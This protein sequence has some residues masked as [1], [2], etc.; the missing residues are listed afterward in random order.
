MVAATM[1][2]P[3]GNY[4]QLNLLSF[5]GE[6]IPSVDE[7]RAVHVFYHDFNRTPGAVPSLGED[8]NLREGFRG[9]DEH[10]VRGGSAAGMTVYSTSKT[11]SSFGYLCS[12][13]RNNWNIVSSF[14]PLTPV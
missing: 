8:Y 11:M 1:D 2:L 6:V 5:Y 14:E 4:V 3:K 12:S 10:Q 9:P 13:F 7:E